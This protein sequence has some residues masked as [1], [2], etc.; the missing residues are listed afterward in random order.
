M[1]GT[2]E[3]RLRYLT[4]ETQ[5]ASRESQSYALLLRGNTRLPSQKRGSNEYNGI[6]GN[7]FAR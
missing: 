6:D 2:Y 3:L 4:T 5:R 7:A 1:T